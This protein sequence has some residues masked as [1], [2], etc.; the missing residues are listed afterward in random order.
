MR[1]T[2]PLSRLLAVALVG[3]T[4]AGAAQAGPPGAYH[5]GLRDDPIVGRDVAG[6]R[7]SPAAAT[8]PSLASQRGCRT[9]FLPRNFS[10]RGGELVRLLDL[11]YTVSENRPGWSDVDAI[12]NWFAQA[13]AE[14]SSNY[15]VDFEGNCIYA[16]NES[17]KAWTQ[18][19]FNPWSISIE[20][21]ATGRERV[22][23][24]AGLRRGARIFAD[25]ARRHGIPIR[26]V[27][28]VG[29]NVPKGITDHNALECRNT[30]TD[31]MPH[32]PYE[33]FMRF[34][35]EAFQT[36][37]R[38]ALVRGNGEVVHRSNVVVAGGAAEEKR[39]RLF[40]EAI[41]ERSLPLV[42]K[43][44]TLRITRQVNP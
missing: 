21:I 8:V 23:P 43:G 30:H 42:R 32:F 2:M 40:L 14:A 37:I 11:H 25:A 29:C 31:V 36:K 18:G 24:D 35:R 41:R 44:V 17:A 33:R 12:W 3:L 20:F 28:P 39:Y 7:L 9:R 15:I 6:E 4:F 26:F 22:W 19:F 13:R 10:S 16:V 34:V 27:D 1:P 5:Q 38:F